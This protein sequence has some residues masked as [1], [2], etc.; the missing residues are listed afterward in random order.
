MSNF[1]KKADPWKTGWRSLE[2]RAWNLNLQDRR[3]KIQDR[4]L[5]AHYRGRYC[6]GA[7]AKDPMQLFTKNIGL[8]KHESGSIGADACPVLEG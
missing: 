1:E 5:K 6:D 2:L 3:S 4:C 7:A 8:C